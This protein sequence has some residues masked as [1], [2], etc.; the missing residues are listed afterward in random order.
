M[1]ALSNKASFGAGCYWGTEN[2]IL[3]KFN[4]LAPGSVK[5]GAV[6]F[7]HPSANAPANPSYREVCSGRTGFVEVYDCE[8]DGKSE[9]YE[10]LCRFFFSFHDPTT[11]DRQ[12]NDRGTQYSSV[13]FFYDD[14]QKAIAERVKGEV[15]DL[16]NQGKIR[17]YESK[18]IT[19]AV[20]PATKFYAAQE[21]HQKYLEKNPWGYCNHAY[22]WKLQDFGW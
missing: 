15:Q 21:D 5:S 13:L 2:Y 9:T 18:Q 10:R 8:F 7:M 12:G 16:I 20:I 4:S 22:R 11:Q 14:A 17:N 1:S 3:K 6:G 19:T